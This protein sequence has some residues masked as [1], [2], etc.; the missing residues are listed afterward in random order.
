MNSAGGYYRCA[1][2][3]KKKYVRLGIMLY[4]LGPDASSV[5][6]QGMKMALSWKSSVSMVKN[7]R[8]GETVGYGRS[9]TAKN[10]VKIATIP[11]GYADGY[12]RALSNKGHVLINGR[13]APIVGKICMDQMMVDVSD[14]DN[15]KVGDIA[16]LIG[17]AEG[18]SITADDIATPAGTIGHDIICGISKRVERLYIN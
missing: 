4:G 7:I 9:Y 11:T 12:P 16:I 18:E 10:D 6:P 13:Y 15:V 17:D 5:L 2:D 8:C 1:S 14:I 3:E